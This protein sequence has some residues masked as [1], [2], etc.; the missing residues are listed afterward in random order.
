MKDNVETHLLLMYW[1]TAL[2]TLGH[3]AKVYGLG[4]VGNPFAEILVF[5]AALATS[6][7]WPLYWSIILWR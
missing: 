1:L 7:L 2:V 3:V 4:N 5:A 6:A